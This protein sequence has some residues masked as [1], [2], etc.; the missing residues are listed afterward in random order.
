M[1]KTNLEKNLE[2]LAKYDQELADKISQCRINESDFELQMAK[3][4]D[5]IMSYK[6]VPLHDTVD[7]Q[8]EA[9]KIFRKL[10]TNKK[11]DINVIFGLGLGYL[12]ERFYISCKG[13]IIVYEP[14]IEILRVTFE[15]VDLSERLKDSKRIVITDTTLKIEKIFETF[16]FEGAGVNLSFLSSY[17]NLFP[18]EIKQ[19][20]DDLGLIHGIYLSNY[21]N[22]FLKIHDWTMCGIENIPEFL[23]HSELE[24]LRGK[25]KNKP[26]VLISAGPSLDATIEA[27]KGFEDK[28]VIFT[29]GTALKSTVK[30]GI[31]ADFLTVVEHHDCSS[32]VNGVDVSQMNLILHPATHKKFHNLNV[33]NAFNYYPNNDFFNKWLCEHINI[34]LDDYSNMGTVSICALFSAMIMGCNPIILLGQDLA[35]MDGK[36]YSKD[37]PYHDVRCVFNEETGK[38]EIKAEDLDSFISSYA[39][40]EFLEMYSYEIAKNLA[41]NKFSEMTKN[42]YFVKGQNGEMLPTESGY[43]TFVRYFENIARNFGHKAKLINSSQGGVLLEGFVH[44]PL[45]EVLGQYAKESICKEEIIEESIKKHRNLFKQKGKVLYDEIKSSVVKLKNC[46]SCFEKGKQATLKLEEEIGKEELD[47]AAI[48][49]CIQ[50]ITSNFFQIQYNILSSNNMVLGLMLPQYLR[51]SNFLTNYQDNFDEEVFNKLL[52]LAKGYFVYGYDR[53]F[54]N[55]LVRIE[56]VRDEIYESIN[57]KSK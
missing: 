56:K 27:L 35:Y 16:Y 40:K 25:F 2:Q 11:A 1:E 12:L 5:I 3:S 55:D 18:A 44:K 4:E 22:L 15:L 32:Q 53:L 57:S 21:R 6:N 50:A 7:P 38:F 51:L 26:A 41:L 52:E 54:H 33:R 24:A 10:S 47:S 46:Q 34:D 8:D 17:A 19:L 39:S 14:N 28:V 43:A 30:H 49:A 31:K 9:Y 23:K 42:L 29:V 45:K 48:R 37:S 20:P 36:C 13:K